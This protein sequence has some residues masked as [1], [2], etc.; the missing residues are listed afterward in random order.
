MLQELATRTGASTWAAVSML[1]FN[2]VWAFVA[3][4]TFRARDEEL[5]AR[6]RLALEGDGDAPAELPPGASPRA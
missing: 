1:F 3:V 4:R 6:A 5:D 2:A